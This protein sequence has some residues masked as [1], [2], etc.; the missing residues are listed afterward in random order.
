MIRVT[1]QVKSL[2]NYQNLGSNSW[3]KLNKVNLKSQTLILVS[4]ILW[5]FTMLEIL[6]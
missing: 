4:R 3:R 2:V 1:S 5:S 6:R